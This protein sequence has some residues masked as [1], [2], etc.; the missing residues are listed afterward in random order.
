MT[1]R[2]AFCAKRVAGRLVNGQE[3]D[4][5]TVRHAVLRDA[6]AGRAIC[7][8]VPAARSAGWVV[9]AAHPELADVTCKGCLA[10]L[11]RRFPQSVGER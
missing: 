2:S 9:E 7:A 6:S 10:A 1:M 4:G 3:R 8:F 11:A 5:G